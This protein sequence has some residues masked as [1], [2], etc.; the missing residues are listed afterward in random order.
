[1]D[2]KIIITSTPKG[3]SWYYV[4]WFNWLVIME[5]KEKLKKIMSNYEK[6]NR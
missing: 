6:Y 2:K 5:R 3:N 4:E 1:M